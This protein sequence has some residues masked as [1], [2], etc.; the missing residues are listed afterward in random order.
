MGKAPRLESDI[1]IILKAGVG[2]T[3]FQIVSPLI[4]A[5]S[6]LTFE[7]F[8]RTYML[9]WPTITLKPNG[10]TMYVTEA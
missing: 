1:A 8:G 9:L 6:F 2:S 4:S 7:T 10:K 3:L 5:H